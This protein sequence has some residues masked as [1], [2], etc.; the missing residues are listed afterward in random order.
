MPIINIPHTVLFFVS[1]T[2]DDWWG[3]ATV[4]SVPGGPGDYPASVKGHQVCGGINNVE[5]VPLADADGLELGSLVMFRDFAGK[6]TLTVT[7]G[8]TAELQPVYVPGPG[9]GEG[10]A[11]RRRSHAAMHAC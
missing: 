8:A 6:L 5:T 4:C 11:H 9:E 3:N 7:L 2:A 10:G 1:Q